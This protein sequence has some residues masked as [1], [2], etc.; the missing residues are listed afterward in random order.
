MRRDLSAIRIDP[1]QWIR[2]RISDL[3]DLLYPTYPSIHVVRPDDLLALTF[4]FVNLT[5]QK[6]QPEEEHAWLVPGKNALILVDFQA[7]NIAEEAFFETDPYLTPPK[8]GSSGHPDDTNPP[9]G[10]NPGNAIARALLARPSRLAFKV[11]EDE[12]PIPYTLEALL[13]RCATYEMNLVSTA[14]PPEPKPP[15]FA[16]W[17]SQYLRNEAVYTAAL[18]NYLGAQTGALEEAPRLAQAYAG[19]ARQALEPG[20][21]SLAQQAILDSRMVAWQRTSQAAGHL[22][23][24]D[25]SFMAAPAINI[26][27]IIA[28]LKP[29]L[30]KPYATETAIEAPFRLLISPNR[31]GAWVH[32]PSP[33]RAADGTVE[34]WHTRLAV[35][36]GS[37]VS[38]KADFYRTIRAVWTRDGDFDPDEPASGPNHVNSPFRMSLDSSDRHN[39]VHVSANYHIYVTNSK[40]KTINYKPEP[41]PVSRLMLSSLGA[42]MDLRGEWELLPDMGLS[43]QE[44]RH[45][46]TLGR[47][48]YVRVVYKGFLLPFMHGASLIK[49][50]ERKFHP[51]SPGNTAYL[52]QRMFILV[53]QPEKTYLPTGVRN[54]NNEQYDFSMPFTWVRINTLVTPNL[55]DPA[56]AT[57]ESQP[58]NVGQDMF[59]P[60]VGT[61][62]FFF[63]LT[64]EDMDGRRVE[65]R[66]PLLFVST[67][68][69]VAYDLNPMQQ[70]QTDIHNRPAEFKQYNLNGQKMAFADSQIPGDTTLETSSLTFEI[71]VPNNPRYT[72][73]RLAQGTD[74]IPRAYPRLVGAQVSIPAIRHLAGVQQATGVTL[75]STYL[76]NGFAK[77]GNNAQVFFQLDGGGVGMDFSS[78]GDRAG[79]LLQPNLQI[80]GLSRLMGPVSG[81]NLDKLTGGEFNAEDF[82][83]GLGAKI[84]GVL[85]LWDI[86]DGIGAG[87]LADALDKVPRLLTENL[88]AAATLL[89]DLDN[90]KKNVDTLAPHLGTLPADLAADYAQVTST[91]SGLVNGSASSADLELALQP[92]QT[93]LGQLKSA[94]PGLPTAAPADVAR[95][96]EVIVDGL[97][98]ELA[99]VAQFVQRLVKALQVPDEVRV[100]FEW[101]PIVKDWNDIFIAQNARN[102]DKAASLVL[103]AEL[104]AAS[105]FKPDPSYSML[106]SLENFTL[107]L[108]GSLESFI[109]IYFRKIEFTAS[110]AKKPDV[111]VKMDG[112]EFVGVLSFVEALRS[113]IP[114]DGFSDPPSL[115]VDETGVRASFSLAL[116]NIAFGVFS[117]QNL[118]LG[119][120]FTVPFLGDPL[121]V[122]FNFC[123]RQSPFLL[124]VTLFGGGGFFA[125]TLDPAGVQVLEASFEFGANIAVDFGVASGGVYVMAGIYYAIKSGN[126]EL[127]GY[128]R[129]G[130]HLSVLGLISVSIELY[131]EL[132]YQFS[133]GKCTGKATLTIE[134]EILFFSASVSISCERKFAGSN[135]DPTF[136]QVMEPYTDPISGQ[137]VLPW[138]EYCAAFA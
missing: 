71:E 22:Q 67:N 45:R 55:D 11:P 83:K 98:K 78:Q 105:N 49:I 54:P 94:L 113:L 46:G 17:D 132:K 76:K 16:L 93:H 10:G 70:A 138:H 68:N 33:V 136:R 44:W 75:H 122:R 69:N 99:S 43:V 3:I 125:I 41:V 62:P 73:L 39:L 9:A 87:G 129:M 59:W 1:I 65:F 58:A 104:Q 23:A 12:P 82:F 115:Q 101:K 103:R 64:G 25:A 60:H 42:W 131:L 90:L 19:L 56:T 15:R 85:N 72:A 2:V 48:H 120:G 36:Q 112:I 77:N 6:A 40:G 121:S 130:G 28:L 13:E 80:K 66:A 84:F 96:L 32:A 57:S 97:V 26:A 20:E 92:L 52:R 50:T 27:A 4:R 123:E 102:G 34:L 38:E 88:T 53:R 137:P 117:L 134:V 86:V 30:R 135:G 100:T 127:T 21:Q 111:D 128:F 110:S 114:L 108:V 5:L 118:S 89:K 124:T 106:C 47:D 24:V 18:Q 116:P 31:Y 126:A 107:D 81:D 95:E 29:V 91:L 133:S 61:R 63:H 51:S 74:D 35:R 8:T 7:Q 119:A 109:R 79:G 37:T 14:L